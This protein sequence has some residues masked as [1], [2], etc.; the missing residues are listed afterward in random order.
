MWFAVR[1]RARH[2]SVAARFFE[3]RA[4]SSFFRLPKAAVV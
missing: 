4:S 3:A 2:K 1:T